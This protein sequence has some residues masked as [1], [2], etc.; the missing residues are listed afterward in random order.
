MRSIQS[1]LQNSLF[2]FFFPPQ[3]VSPDIKSWD[4][5][6]RYRQGSKEM[7][8]QRMREQEYWN[9]S[10][11]RL[12]CVSEIHVPLLQLGTRLPIKETVILAPSLCTQQARSD[13]RGEGFLCSLEGRGAES[14]W[15][16]LL[17]QLL[18]NSVACHT[19]KNQYMYPVTAG[20]SVQH[21]CTRVDVWSPPSTW[22]VSDMHSENTYAEL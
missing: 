14:K 16:L 1:P 18:G 8:V 5:I 4:A 21:T 3:K 15:V 2:F 11:S 7:T 20:M 22:M 19:L 13:P 9:Q 10:K 12:Y 6:R 17:V